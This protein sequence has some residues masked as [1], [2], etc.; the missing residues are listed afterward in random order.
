KRPF[1]KPRPQK[2][3][4]V[5]AVKNEIRLY[6]RIGLIDR[7]NLPHALPCLKPA[8]SVFVISRS[9]MIVLAA[10]AILDDDKL[11][12]RIGIV[13]EKA[14]ERALQQILPAAAGQHERHIAGGVWRR[15]NLHRL[16]YRR[17]SARTSR[18]IT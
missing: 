9:Q 18:R 17:D 8:N 7:R 3:P 5:F 15:T 16:V 2:L 11:A 13:E 10:I 4:I 14:V 1:D 6:A 12:D